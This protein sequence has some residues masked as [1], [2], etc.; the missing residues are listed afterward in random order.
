MNKKNLGT[1]FSKSF[2]DFFFFCQTFATNLVKILSNNV[3][4]INK[5]LIL[6][7]CYTNNQLI[8]KL[9]YEKT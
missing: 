3:L 6:Q 8:F 4:Y 1:S 2:I 9:N 5:M 7:L